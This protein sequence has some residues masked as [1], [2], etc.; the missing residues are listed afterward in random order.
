MKQ[1]SYQH[2]KSSSTLKIICPDGSPCANQAIDIEQTKH[3]FLFGIGGFDTVEM[4]GG[5][6]DGQPTESGRRAFLEERMERLMEIHNFFT[7]PFYLGRYEPEEGKPDH[8]RV[9]AGAKWL[10]ERGVTL[11]GHP[12]CWHTVWPTWLMKYSNQDILKKALERIDRDVIEYK[13]VID[14]WD[15]INE[16]VI[17]PIFDKYD[18]AITRVCKELGRVSMV[19][20]VFEAARAANPHAILLLND[21]D[22]STKFE[23]LIDGCLEAGIPI[24]VIGI[25]SHQ[26]QGYWGADKVVEVLERYEHFGLPIHFTENTIISGDIMPPHIVDLNDWQVNEWLST[27]EGEERQAREMVEMY[28]LLFAHPLVEAITHWSPVDGL[29]LNAPAG[30]LRADNSVKPVFEELTKKIKGEWWTKETL[31]TDANGEVTVCGFRG[32]YKLKCCDNSG[33]FALDGK[34]DSQSVYLG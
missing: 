30:V 12:L 10:Q 31:T 15:V 13:G 29:W 24:D 16:V 23:I 7:L 1:K 34:N 25:Q 20:E 18:N 8:R 4:A 33:A 11:K 9:M 5:M 17:M 2:R 3:E 21:F 6:P 14:I 28:E 22:I 26:H 32:D 19:R 27:P